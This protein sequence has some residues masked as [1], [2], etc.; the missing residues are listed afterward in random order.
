MVNF[1]ED[2]GTVKDTER[3]WTCRTKPAT[4][5]HLVFFLVKLETKLPFYLIKMEIIRLRKLVHFFNTVDH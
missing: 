3:F 2:E 4:C 1:K 5:S